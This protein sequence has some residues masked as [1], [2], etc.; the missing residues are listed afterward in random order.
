MSTYINTIKEYKKE[1]ILLDETKMW[2]SLHNLEEILCD[3]EK[4]QKDKFWKVM[5]ELHEDFKGCHF[6][7]VYAKYE[8]SE[9]YHTGL[10]GRMYKGEKFDMYK[11]EEVHSKYRGV[12]KSSDTIHDVYVAINA[13][14]HDYFPIF[15]TWFQ[16]E[17]ESVLHHKIIEAAISFWFRDEDYLEGGKIW[18]YFKEME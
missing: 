1:G 3:A 4:H 10:D 17:E 9:M 5:R 14:Y 12:I 16:G 7:E 18:K 6:N 2:N 11:A 13:Q 15:K 8:V